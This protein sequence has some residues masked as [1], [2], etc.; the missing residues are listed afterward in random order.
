MKMLCKRLGFVPR[1]PLASRS[2]SARRL[3]RTAPLVLAAGCF[4]IAAWRAA[5]PPGGLP[6]GGDAFLAAHDPSGLGQV[7]G[8]RPSDRAV[9]KPG[10]D[11]LAAARKQSRRAG[12]ARRAAEGEAE[13]EQCLTRAIANVSENGPA[14]Q[15]DLATLLSGFAFETYN[16]PDGA[17][18][19]KG[20]DGCD[21]A[22]LSDDFV[23]S[24][25]GGVLV[26]KVMAAEGLRGEENMGESIL[27][28]GRPDPYVL[29]NVIEDDKGS[30]LKQ[31]GPAAGA[32]EEG[33]LA[34]SVDVQRTATM[35][36]CGDNDRVTWGDGEGE[37][38]R[39]YI[40]DLSKARL[41]IRV[42]DENIA[43]ADELL[44]AAELELANFLPSGGSEGVWNGSVP[45]LYKEPG[46]DWD[47]AVKSAAGLALAGVASGGLAI[48][49]GAAA[50]VTKAVL[51]AGTSGTLEL[52]L[53]Y[54]PLEVQ[55]K[56]RIAGVG[57]VGG[58]PGL[59]WSKL[60]EGVGGIAHTAPNYDFL[61]FV[62]HRVTDTQAGLWRDEENKRLVLSF[63]GTQ[64]DSLQ[65]FM[66]DVSI[67]KTPF[68]RVEEG[69][70]ELEY[71][72]PWVHAGFRGAL[73]SVAQRLKALIAAACPRPSDYELF[74]TGHSLGGALATLMALDLASGLEPSRGL[75]KTPRKAPWFT[76]GLFGG[77]AEEPPPRPDMQFKRVALYSI[78]APRVGNSAFARK[79]TEAVPEY[80]RVVN[81][82][83]V[84][85]RTPRGFYVHG[86]RGI[87]FL[88]KTAGDKAPGM[89]PVDGLWVEGESE[90]RC[91][92]RDDEVLKN[93]FESG[94]L[95]GNIFQGLQKEPIQELQEA[96]DRMAEDAAQL[97]KRL[98]TTSGTAREELQQLVK[99]SE[100]TVEQLRAAADRAASAGSKLAELARSGSKNDTQLLAA[101]E[102]ATD[103]VEAELRKAL[104]GI[105]GLGKDIGRLGGSTKEA[106]EG[107]GSGSSA[108]TS[109]AVQESVETLSDTDG[110]AKSALERA[111]RAADLAQ[112]E[113]RRVM[114]DATTG[115]YASVI[116]LDADYIDA[117]VRL[118]K[119]MTTGEAVVQHLEPSY[120]Q[121]MSDVIKASK[122]ANE[123]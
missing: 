86:G 2:L 116:G 95:I 121:S 20:E 103:D 24:V 17:R 107:A 110:V 25:Y 106:G 6:P 52:E 8:R 120:F 90:G 35:W 33:R 11:R 12:L 111:L 101:E 14:F 32:I 59:D 81:N 96:A 122:A 87:L 18:W 49:A 57:A 108:A 73:D 37:T 16:T 61:G 82:Q 48:A 47:L 70:P 114:G 1:P 94:A 76:L 58:T 118:L 117:E 56:E 10:H 93:P 77:E 67:V 30:L 68:A 104:D 34:N 41:G 105:L 78:G 26:V 98:E 79:M 62:D 72:E 7:S 21:V 39:L 40:K 46:M 66:T 84:V 13:L 112:G 38:V 4:V 63:R 92:T 115:Q 91:P 28:G 23:P 100:K 89:C 71:S 15:L 55:E 123:V 102:Q 3:F 80:F 19:E 119:A 53:S 83:D 27:T 45:L 113:I 99:G 9:A 64:Q 36:R 44:G 75:P 5:A 97:R 109:K 60:A 74:L 29:L 50:M 88:N 22:L 31:A 42:V 51:P 85:C 69:E 54:L 65:D 43:K